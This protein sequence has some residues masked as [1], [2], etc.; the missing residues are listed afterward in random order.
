[1]SRLRPTATLIHFLLTAGEASSWHRVRSDE[2]WLAHLG[3]VILEYGGTG[4][5][6]APES[7]VLVGA[8]PSAGQHPQVLVPGG[9]WQRTVPTEA[10]A[11]VSCVVSPGFDYD[12]FELAEEG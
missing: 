9:V 7:T 10:E 6:P 2:L 5:G 8:D 12:D 3:T 4:A 11:L 1:M